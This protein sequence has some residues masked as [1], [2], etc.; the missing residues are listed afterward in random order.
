[1][2]PDSLAWPG[3]RTGL[4]SSEADE[5]SKANPACA[6]SGLIRLQPSNLAQSALVHR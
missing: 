6:L 1:M 3:I 4:L 5:T 2:S